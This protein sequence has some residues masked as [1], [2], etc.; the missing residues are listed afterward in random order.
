M[1]LFDRLNIPLLKRAQESRVRFVQIEHAP[2]N[3]TKIWEEARKYDV[4]LL[5]CTNVSEKRRVDLENTINKVSSL[6]TRSQRE[7]VL[8]TVF[9][10]KEF[11][12]QI[13]RSLI[14]E[15]KEFHYIDVFDND[16]A[17]TL[18]RESRTLRKLET[19]YFCQGKF[20]LSFVYS[21][22]ATIARA[23]SDFAR[24]EVVSKQIEDLRTKSSK[25]WKNKTICVI[26]GQNH[27]RTYHIFKRDYP[28]VESSRTFLEDDVFVFSLTTEAKN[29]LLAGSPESREIA[30]KRSFIAQ[31]VLFPRS[32]SDQDIGERIEISDKIARNLS[33]TEI[34]EI[35]TSLTMIQQFIRENFSNMPDL[36]TFY[37]LKH[38]EILGRQIIEKHPLFPENSTQVVCHP[39]R[40]SGWVAV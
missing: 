24:E 6:E 27:S 8:G 16:E 29:R 19:D 28:S 7:K 5:E 25:K 14:L 20:D 1:E 30:F 3:A 22:K 9:S 4:V 38:A 32:D 10:G 13:I 15:G 12:N 35:F 33:T 40:H 23:H 36:A 18:R 34:D 2:E 31:N 26:Q 21:K 39:P 17:N 37:A 11:D